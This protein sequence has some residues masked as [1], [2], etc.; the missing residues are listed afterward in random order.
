MHLGDHG[1]LRGGRQ[2]VEV[3]SAV[4]V[5]GLVLQRTAEEVGSGELD[6]VAVL[7]EPRTVAF[8]G[9]ASGE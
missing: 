5:L 7:V 6:G 1:L 9:R 2:A 8:T 3:K 4:E